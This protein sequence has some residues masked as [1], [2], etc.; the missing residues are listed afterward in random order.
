M[1]W[2]SRSQ[3]KTLIQDGD[4]KSYFSNMLLK[5]FDVWT[6]LSHFSP[7]KCCFYNGYTSCKYYKYYFLHLAM[8][9]WKKNSHLLSFRLAPL[10]NHRNRP[11]LIIFL[12]FS[13]GWSMERVLVH[14]QS[15]SYNSQTSEEYQLHRNPPVSWWNLILHFKL[16]HMIIF[17]SFVGYDCIPM[18]GYLLEN[19]YQSHK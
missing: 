6:D 10:K 3:R 8:F 4:T 2:V 18:W 1:L 13:P 14:C 12:I 15:D 16:P 9:L 7:W 17:S 19:D 5:L 11:K